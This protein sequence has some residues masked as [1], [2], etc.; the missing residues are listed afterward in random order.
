MKK[1]KNNFKPLPRP[2]II[3]VGDKDLNPQPTK[4][5]M[6]SLRNE[7]KS[8]TAKLE[9][10]FYRSCDLD[11]EIN[12]ERAEQIRRLSFFFWTLEEEALRFAKDLLD[13]IE[14]EIEDQEV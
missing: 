6:K 1:N 5:N 2:R 14:S 7:G 10:L 11:L 12:K 8:I 9:N 3:G 13:Q 4:K